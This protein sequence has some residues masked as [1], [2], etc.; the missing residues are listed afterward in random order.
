MWPDPS[1]ER[2]SQGVSWKKSSQGSETR[3]RRVNTPG[4]SGQH[5]AVFQA[6]KYHSD[7]ETLHGPC[8]SS[9]FS[10]WKVQLTPRMQ[11]PL[12]PHSPDVS[13]PS[14]TS[15][16]HTPSANIGPTLLSLQTLGP[17]VVSVGNTT[18]SLQVSEPRGEG[19]LSKPRGDDP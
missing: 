4:T 13:P 3:R 11:T 15:S 6:V 14:P 7:E 10:I 16:E 9:P 19:K 5:E 17:P 8:W 2:C 1:L 12:M 18:D